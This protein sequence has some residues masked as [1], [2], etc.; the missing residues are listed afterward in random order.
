MRPL[1]HSA[2]ALSLA[3]NGVNHW[4]LKILSNFQ[5]G[6]CAGL[7]L[8]PHPALHPAPHPALHP[9][10]PPRAKA[11][12]SLPHLRGGSNYHN[13]PFI[14]VYSCPSFVLL[15]PTSWDIENIREYSS[16]ASRGRSC[17]GPQIMSQL[18]LKICRTFLWPAQGEA[19]ALLPN[20]MIQIIYSLTS[21]NL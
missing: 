3:I 7:F 19:P 14:F 13:E 4:Y 11:R 20:V 15:L 1:A 16:S 17:A 9:A 5:A 6:G 12:G 8:A 10:P 18:L 21:E 2:A